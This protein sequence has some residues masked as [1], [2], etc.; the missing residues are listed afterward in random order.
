[1]N[2]KILKT[3]GI[4]LFL[5]FLI[6]SKFV[7]FGFTS[8]IDLQTTV[9]LQNFLP[10]FVIT[11]FSLFSIIGSAEIASVFMLTIWFLI[12]SLRKIHVLIL[13]GLVTLIEIAG[14]TIIHQNPPPI[15]FLRTNLHLGFPSGSVSGH[16]FSYPSGHSA[17]AAFISGIL[18]I[19]ILISKK[20][21]EQQKKLFIAL[22]L[23]FDAV[24]FV[25]RVYLGEH[26][27]TDVVG[28]ALLG[29][30]IALISSAVIIKR[31]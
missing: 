17:R 29:F 4:L 20:L 7:L 30:S 21:T 6:L 24:M 19:A 14:K 11:P 1:M 25:S 26:W 8:G 31:A 27:T 22:I 2:Q 23:I 18:I 28:G 3:W 16:L 15:E 5:A 10:S 12:P 9:Y 13:Y